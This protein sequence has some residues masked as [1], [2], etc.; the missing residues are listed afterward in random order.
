MS[1]KNDR[2]FRIFD[3]GGVMCASQQKST[4]ARC[5]RLSN[6]VLKGEIAVFA[7]KVWAVCEERAKVEK[8]GGRNSSRNS[9]KHR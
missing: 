9:G 1:F 6:A 8:S 7:R 4:H 5:Q 2:S 3:L